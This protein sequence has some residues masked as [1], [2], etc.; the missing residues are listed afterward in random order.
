MI[1]R[2]LLLAALLAATPALAQED[3]A[4]TARAAGANQLGVLEYC[5][6]HGDVGADAVDAQRGV[7]SRMPQSAVS[8]SAQ[9]ELG[10]AGTMKVPN[11]QQFTLN[12]LAQK[13]G[14]TVSDLC[15]RMGSATLQ[16][17][18]AMA[19]TPSGGLFPSIPSVPGALTA[20]PGLPS[21]TAFPGVP[22]IP[23][24]APN[25]TAV[26]GLPPNPAVPGR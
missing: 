8:T 1:H 26:P 14:T 7:I 12:D 17:A 16:V 10:K 23:G 25:L 2:A 3:A 15:K 19:Q 6:A 24:G 5:Q 9:E 4:A 21:G 11:G 20:I 18:A 13:Q 22:G